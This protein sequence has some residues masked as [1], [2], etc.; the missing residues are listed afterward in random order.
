MPSFEV[1]VRAVGSLDAEEQT[2]MRGA[3]HHAAGGTVSALAPKA[4]TAKIPIV[5]ATGADPVESGLVVGLNRPGGNITGVSFLAKETDPTRL[6][7]LHE[8]YHDHAYFLRASPLILNCP[9]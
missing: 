1:L 2:A 9:A 7:L 4:A 8:I 6:E 5:F 3:L